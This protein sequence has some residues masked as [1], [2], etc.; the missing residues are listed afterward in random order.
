MGFQIPPESRSKPRFPD[1]DRVAMGE[2]SVQIP[3]LEAP[4]ASPQK[5]ERETE[6]RE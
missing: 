6:E 2:A 5:A 4:P 3:P 1:P